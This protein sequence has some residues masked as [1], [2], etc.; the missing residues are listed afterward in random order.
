MCAKRTNPD[1][2]YVAA[3]EKGLLTIEAFSPANERL[4]VSGV[5]QYVGAS[6][7]AARRSL[8]TL[9]AMGYAESNGK[10]FWLTAKVLRLGYAYLSS[11][12]LPRLA[13]P[14]ID[15]LGEQVDDVAALGVLDGTE[16]VFIARSVQRRIISA[17]TSVGTRLPAF[18]SATGRVLLAGQPDET[19]AALL[20][21]AAPI[22]KLTT[23]TKSVKA[24]V[25]AEIRR[26][27]EQGFSVSDEE[28]EIGLRSIAVP[29]RNGVGTVV[30]ALG[31]SVLSARM[32]VER[33]R[34]QFL[35]LLAA[36]SRKL[37]ALI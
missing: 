31:I 17:V 35:P 1:R 4:T 19:V 15:G 33:L 18:S 26:A 21:R 9:T 23:K 2:N 13:Q 36:A 27:R 7:A 10:H 3:L 16:T 11:V 14:I 24:D 28:I 25:L 8:Y 34:K 5:A 29:V 22:R 32:P 20:E 37:G 30:A 6:R 12:P